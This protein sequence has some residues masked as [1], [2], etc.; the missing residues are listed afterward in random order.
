MILP[1]ACGPHAAR[2]ASDEEPNATKKAAPAVLG[3]LGMP[4]VRHCH[5]PLR[6]PCGGLSNVLD[7]AHH[8]FT[9]RMTSPVQ[10]R[11]RKCDDE[12]S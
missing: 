8:F 9:S 12:A 10:H 11:P 1:V 2:S 3:R 6:K 5:Q 7:I 4:R